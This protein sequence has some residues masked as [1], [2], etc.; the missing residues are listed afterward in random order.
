MIIFLHITGEEIQNGDKLLF[1]LS[2]FAESDDSKLISI[3]I[4]K[5]RKAAGEQYCAMAIAD[6]INQEVLNIDIEARIVII[7]H[8]NLMFKLGPSYNIYASYSL[9]TEIIE[10]IRIHDSFGLQKSNIQNAPI[11]AYSWMPANILMRMRSDNS[12]LFSPGVEYLQLPFESDELFKAID[13]ARSNLFIEPKSYSRFFYGSGVFPVDSTRH[14]Q[15]NRFGIAIL[16]HALKKIYSKIYPSGTLFNMMDDTIIPPMG[17]DIAQLMYRFQRRLNDIDLNN[18]QQNLELIRKNH[19]E[20]ARNLSGKKIALIDD[21]ATEV[22]GFKGVGWKKALEHLLNRP[23]SIDDLF[24]LYGKNAQEIANYIKVN[25]YACVLLDV[26]FPG[27]AQK[28]NKNTKH[29]FGYKVL[30]ALRKACPAIPVIIVTSVN[31]TWRH[32]QLLNAGADAIWVKE[33]IDELRLPKESLY[34][35]VRLLELISRVTGPSY[36]FLQTMHDAIARLCVAIDD[37]SV[38]WLKPDRFGENLV[39]VN[40]IMVHDIL[41]DS[42]QFHRSFIREKTMNFPEDPNVLIKSRKRYRRDVDRESEFVKTLIIRLTKIIELVHGMTHEAD[43]QKRVNSAKIGGRKKSK[44]SH[45]IEVQR[46]DWI[47]FWLYNLRNEC[48]HHFPDIRFRINASKGISEGR[49]GENFISFLLSY[50][51]NDELPLQSSEEAYYYK[52]R[53]ENNLSHKNGSNGNIVKSNFIKQLLE[54]KDLSDHEPF[55][56]FIRNYSLMKPLPDMYYERVRESRTNT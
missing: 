52:A 21:E 34:N 41:M 54:C 17:K 11:I 24:S 26:R 55:K 27:Q 10:A 48:A 14:S 30:K 9:G 23:D 20:I 35:I 6:I 44:N 42:F 5:L 51:L 8:V 40:P 53:E 28:K 36:S 12:K 16:I 18:E 22:G 31:K 39:D 56:Q 15:A 19:E 45:R 38:W 37:K 43:T 7:L 47:G 25:K 2:H 46:G 33:G 13:W 4:E 1:E 49:C 50:L 29:T 32:N 3:P